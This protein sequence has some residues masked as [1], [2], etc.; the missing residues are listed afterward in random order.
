M[1]YKTTQAPYKLKNIIAEKTRQL[2]KSEKYFRTLIETNS[3]AL[4]LMD[5]NGKVLY[6]T[7]STEKILGYTFEEMQHIDGIELIHPDY[8]EE[9]G[10]FF[11]EILK[12]PGLTVERKHKIKHKNGN[13]LEIEGT[14][15]NLLGDE[16]VGAIVLSYK[17][18]TEKKLA[19]QMLKR[20]MYEL[21]L[22]NEVN[23]IILRDLDKASLFS[24]ICECIVRSGIYS[25]AWVSLKPENTDVDQTVLPLASG[26]NP[27]YLVN[28]KIDLNDPELSNGTTGIA[29]KTGKVFISNNTVDA[30]FFQLWTDRAKAF[31]IKSSIALPFNMGD[32]RSGALTIYSAQTNVFDPYEVSILKRLVDNLSIAIQ[33][34]D[35]RRILVESENRFRSAFEDSAI[36]M[37][38]TSIM[39]ESKGKWLKVNKSLCDMLGYTQDE[40][41]SRNFMQITHP[42]DLPRDLSAQDRILKG[43]D[44]I[45][46]AEKRYLHKDGRIVWANLNVSIVRDKDRKPMY[47]AAQ[48][49]NIT[50]KV[51]SQVKFQKLVETFIVGVYMIQDNKFV[52]VNPQVIEESGYTEDEILGMPVDHFIYQ[53]DL[54]LVHD[55]MNARIMNDQKTVRYEARIR[56]KNG[57]LIWCEILGGSSRYKGAPAL[58]GTM[59][60]I[61]E[62]KVM[63]DEL[64]RSEANLKSMFD[65]TDVLFLLVNT[66][67]KIIALNQQMKDG[68]IAAAGIELNEGDNLVEVMHPEK[69]AGA[70]AIYDEVIETNQSKNY[71]TTYEKNGVYTHLLANVK[72]IN[73]GTRVIGI[74]ISAIDMTE[75]K[76]MTLD[77]LNHVNAIEEQNKKLREIAWM[78]S[79]VVRAPLVRIMALVDLFRNQQNSE[80]D[81]DMILDYIVA[82]ADELDEIIKNISEKVS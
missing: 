45:Y 38:L 44:D 75:R 70:K 73:D 5:A 2:A 22:L 12:S 49:E 77:L 60:N 42:D 67:Y 58:M 25:M 63:Y 17:D 4:V 81:K 29:L 15:R 47:M 74:C 71:E 80:V 31:E 28:I 57:T 20:S 82:S 43:Q 1:A 72:P 79:H 19:E 32:N 69:R 13:Y 7:L 34:I 52:Y 9:D 21:S 37:G 39:E 61:N 36:G 14:Y 65:T 11:G 18:I 59:V 78:Q 64:L 33:N 27:D 68:Y 51:E 62:W 55:M 35:N 6:Q 41:L 40:L 53:E 26:G 30:P 54:K 56:Q 8:R 16:N 46:R 48:V 23:D 24:D 66:S 50:E 10:K 3:E 76:K